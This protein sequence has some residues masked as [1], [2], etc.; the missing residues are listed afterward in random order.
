[1]SQG[2]EGF[3]DKLAG[4]FLKKSAYLLAVDTFHRSRKREL[5]AEP[6]GNR[7]TGFTTSIGKIGKAVLSGTGKADN[8]L[9]DGLMVLLA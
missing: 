9:P 3:F 4:D 5:F 8:F 6:S 1:M 2:F 7:C